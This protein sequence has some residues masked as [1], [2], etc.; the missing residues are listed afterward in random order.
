[1]KK[2][3]VLGLNMTVKAKLTVFS[4]SMIA[5]IVI[6]ATMASLFVSKF[7]ATHN[8]RYF[9]YGEGSMELSMTAAN[10]SEVKVHLQN[11]LYLY[12]HNEAKRSDE[13]EKVS[14]SIEDAVFYLTSFSERIGDYDA[15]IVSSYEKYISY[16]DQYDVC[17]Q[18]IISYVEAG[19]LEKAKQELVN[20]ATPLANNA[21]VALDELI[22]VLL[23]AG[24][25]TTASIDGQVERVRVILSIIFIVAMFFAGVEIVFLLK[26]IT[27][28]MKRLSEAAQKLAVGDVEVDCTKLYDD[29]MGAVLDEFAKMTETIKEQAQVAEKM[30]NG[31]MTV[32]V[33]PRS[34]KDILG[35][36]LQKLVRDNNKTIGNIKE[37]TNQVTVGAEQVATASQS[38]AQGSTQQ[39][40]AIEQVT[41]AMD[42]IAVHTK[43]NASKASE[44]NDLV[45]NVKE[46]AVSGNDQMKAMI[47]AMEDINDASETISKIIKVIDDI[48]FQTNI[49]ALNAA[50]EAAR[51]GVHGKGFAVVAEEV[52]NLAA[53]SASAASETAEMIE[54]SIHKVNNGTKLAEQTAQSLDEIVKSIDQIV[55]LISNIAQAS[56]DQATAVS[57]I[58][59][60]I[61]QVS[62]VV[63]TNSATSEQC[64]AAS[65][66]LSNQAATLRKLVANYKLKSGVHGGYAAEYEATPSYAAGNYNEQIISLDGD[67]GKY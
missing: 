9:N 58:N 41:V 26:S 65:E 35:K 47:H 25:D 36:A 55:G 32:S 57:Q 29:D 63:Q 45:H 37:S 11:A 61:G 31:D 15:N 20:T 50:V 24:E 30:A 18:K 49:L 67:F 54:D 60:A 14:A 2:L 5:I 43:D 16:I 38:L 66:E 13:M 4:T 10:F 28:P 51:A 48:A 17:M 53:K 64:A 3:R 22:A 62:S 21:E 27:V 23:Q 6:V 19:N 42:D 8:E 59:Q 44:A 52:R 40:S 34:D 56:N 1:M 39:A 7:N 12:E 46:M 33:E